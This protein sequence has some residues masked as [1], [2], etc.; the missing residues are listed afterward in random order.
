MRQTTSSARGPVVA[1]EAVNVQQQRLD[2]TTN[3]VPPSDCRT[4]VVIYLTQGSCV[5]ALLLF[6]KCNWR[7]KSSQTRRLSL[8]TPHRS[9]SQLTASALCVESRAQATPRGSESFARRLTGCANVP[10]QARALSKLNYHRAAAITRRN[11]I[12]RCSTTICEIGNVFAKGHAS[13][14]DD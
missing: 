1:G 9:Q 4:S 3:T 11:G 7:R 14:C 2:V 10:H 8:H 6:L 5:N 12:C 13:V